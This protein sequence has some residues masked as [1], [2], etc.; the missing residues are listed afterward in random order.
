[1]QWFS[2]ALRKRERNY[3][4]YERELFAV[5]KA[6]N[7]FRM[8]LLG[9]PFLLRTDHRAL[10]AIFNSTL[11]TS[12]RVVKWVMSLQEFSFSLEYIKDS[13]NIVADA[14]S[15]IHADRL[16]H[17]SPHLHVEKT[18]MNEMRNQSSE[19]PTGTNLELEAPPSGSE[20]EESENKLMNIPDKPD[21][22]SRTPPRRDL[23]SVLKTRIMHILYS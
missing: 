18:F 13:E 7:A 19:L 6:C 12:A 10:S 21:F 11:R 3:S 17:V 14:L 20:S 2:Q 22:L 4:V 5:V 15:R 8:F 1:M 23:L 16:L 9:M